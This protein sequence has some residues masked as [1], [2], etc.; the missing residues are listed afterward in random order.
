MS[1]VPG[2]V[3]CHW[4]C[5]ALGSAALSLAELWPSFSTRSSTPSLE[6]SQ[7]STTRPDFCCKCSLHNV[8]DLS[9]LEC[10]LHEALASP[11]TKSPQSC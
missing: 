6:K 9:C 3:S 7:L 10:L 8:Q 5:P 2:Y 1:E 4:Q 11:L